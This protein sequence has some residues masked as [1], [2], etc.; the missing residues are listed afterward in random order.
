MHHD[1][2]GMNAEIGEAQGA[3]DRSGPHRAAHPSVTPA[4]ASSIGLLVRRVASEAL[5]IRS[6]RALLFLLCAGGIGLQLRQYLANKSLSLDESFLALNILN[7]PL[8]GLFHSLDFNQA[9]PPLFLAIQKLVEL[10]IGNHEYS[11]RL[12]PLL[13]AASAVTIFPFLANRVLD[14]RGALLAVALF[15]L[16]DPLISYSSVDKQYSTDVALAVLGFWIVVRLE[17]RL[18]EPRPLVILTGFAAIATWISFPALFI[19]LGIS[20][21]LTARAFVKRQW[22]A[23]IPGLAAGAACLLSLTVVYFVAVKELGHLQ[24]SLAGNAGALFGTN[25]SPSNL[26][27]I[28]GRLRYVSGIGHVVVLGL[29]IEKPIAVAALL[30]CVAG[31]ISIFRRNAERA[32]LLVSPL[33]F[34][35]I[36]AYAHKYPLFSRTLLFLI[37][38][39]VLL[40][41]EGMTVAIQR[42]QHRSLKTL[43]VLVATSIVASIAVQPFKH[44]LSPRTEEQMKPVMAYL[45][46][47]QRPTDTLF[48][49]YPSQYGFRYYLQCSCGPSSVERAYSSQLWPARFAAGGTP[50]YAPA[51]DSSPPHFLVAEFR[52]RDPRSYLADFQKL[53]GRRR[54]WVLYSDIPLSARKRLTAELDRLGHRRATFRGGPDLSSATLDLYDFKRS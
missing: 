22:R 38:T 20:A 11:L 39:I 29:D 18:A 15:I 23:G 7:R 8:T 31:F 26:M 16:S 13:A 43:A 12:A 21:T 25:L 35:I 52:N 24:A 47:H 9:A 2:D 34:L 53:R 54:V 33:P 44:A 48:I 4:D 51:L 28:A 1:S 27:D 45:A 5:A 37:P 17:S 30:F 49:Y 46:R 40:L 41:A 36:A 6:S 10:G 42:L 19:T 14:R 3:Q 50:Q 32:I